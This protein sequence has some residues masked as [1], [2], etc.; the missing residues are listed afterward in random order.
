MLFGSLSR[1]HLCDGGRASLASLRSARSAPRHVVRLSVVCLSMCKAGAPRSPCFARLARHSDM[2]FGSLSCVYLCE[3]GGHPARLAS[4]GS[5]GAPS[6]LCGSPS[7]VSV[8]VTR[9]RLARLASLSSLSAL[10][11]VATVELVLE[12][13]RMLTDSIH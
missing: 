3:R 13:C 4:L 10:F 12:S 8:C 1:V 7:C 11:E 5:L 9:G 6:M 2:L